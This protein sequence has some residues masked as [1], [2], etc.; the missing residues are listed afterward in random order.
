VVTG[1]PTANS[2]T[3]NSPG[4]SNPGTE[5]TADG[6][7][8]WGAYPISRG[9][10]GV[11]GNLVMRYISV[12]DTQQPVHLTNGYASLT[13]EY[14]FVGRWFG[15]SLLHSEAFSWQGSGC[16]NS[17]FN[18]TTIRYS[19][20]LDGESS[21]VWVPL[22]GA[23]MSELDIYG[24]VVAQTV[25]NPY[26]RTGYGDGVFDCI[27][28][29]NNTTCT[30]VQIYNNTFA[31]IKDTPA[32]KTGIVVES[33]ISTST[34]R[35]ENNLWYNDDPSGVASGMAAEDHNTLLNTSV[36]S[37]A[38]FT[39]AHDFGTTSGS[40][41]PFIADTAASPLITGFE[42]SSET[43]DAHL[44]DGV[45]T[46]SLLPGNNIDYNGHTR[47]GDGTWERGAF[48][49]IPA[50]NP[51]TLVQV[52]NPTYAHNTTKYVDITETAGHFLVV[53][54]GFKSN[55]TAA[56][57]DSIGN[58]WHPLTAYVNNNAGCGTADSPSSGM[59]LWY[60]ENIRGGSNRVTLTLS[61]LA[62][63]SITV[64]EYSGVKTSGSLSTSTGSISTSVVSSIS[65]GNMSSVAAN[66][67]IIGAFTDTDQARAN[68]SPGTGYTDLANTGIGAMLEHLVPAGPGTYNPS[69]T[70]N[71]GADACG[72][73]AGAVFLS[74]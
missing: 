25:G 63:L 6:L 56:V 74:Q 67:L 66:N 20:F 12:H 44:N 48:E 55:V 8:T 38:L 4:C 29:S 23:C 43:I 22:F 69:A 9:G 64:A 39:G 2:I 47:A 45:S 21:G 16:P 53:A 10:S 27:N 52:A 40:A 5:G 65:P 33:P 54:A 61:G 72:V 59:Q 73:A 15:N 37:N 3:Y 26:L 62:Y 17:S 14:N 1:N 34:W 42:L 41:D 57:S 58:T 68:M 24:N 19:Y 60:A 71:N 32:G 35:V 18:T 28:A 11:A 49:F 70:Y 51:I 50:G 7:Y 46:S 30:N 31:N 36:V 13:F